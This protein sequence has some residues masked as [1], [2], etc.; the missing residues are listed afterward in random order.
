MKLHK[1]VYVQKQA[2]IVWYRYLT[3]KLLEEL[4]FEISQVDECVFYRKKT[5]Y[6][7]FTDDSILAGPDPEEIESDG[8]MKN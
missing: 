3:Q 4:V 2:G 6:I 8:Q 1:N 7:L 5:V